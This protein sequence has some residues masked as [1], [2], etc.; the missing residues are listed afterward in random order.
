MGWVGGGR[1]MDT[2]RVFE[3]NCTGVCELLCGMKH[4]LGGKPNR[5]GVCEIPYG[6]LDMLRERKPYGWL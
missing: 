6:M 4:M 5:P 1:E 2:V 3:R